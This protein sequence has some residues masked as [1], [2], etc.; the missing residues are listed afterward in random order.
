[1]T[2]LCLASNCSAIGAGDYL[3]SA[4]TSE[5]GLRS[6]SVTAIAQTPDGYLWVG[7][8]N[9]LARFDGVRFV[10]FDPDNTPALPRA[11]IRRLF[12]DPAGTLW[13]NTYDG[14]LVSYREGQFTTQWR[15]DGSPDATISL[16]SAVSNRPVFLRHTGELIRYRPER[17]G[18]N[19][20][21]VLHPPGASS[22]EICAEDRDG[23]I[24]C[25]G[26]DQ[27]LWRLVGDAFEA[28]P[29]NSGFQGRVINAL[30]ADAKGHIWVGTERELAVWNGT[31]FE[32]MTPTNGEA[33]LNVAYVY[34]AKDGD[35]W[36]I[37]N[38]R[39]R[40]MRG[41][42]WVFEAEA[43]RGVFTGWLDRIGM[44]EDH[45]RPI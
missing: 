45:T 27:Q 2:A 30:V 10:R 41:R 31:R 14:S 18:S 28:A 9:G 29:T 3:I 23:A 44:R 16:V 21:Q 38:N 4:W 7:T 25:R 22:G 35:A 19:Q 8:Y 42:Q 6:S 43:C 39:V 20:W 26:R 36:I 40:R 32:T 33:V 24:W 5:D 15:G 34:P 13:I 11:R 12:V 37:A 1:M 17:A